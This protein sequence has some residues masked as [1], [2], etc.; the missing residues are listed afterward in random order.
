[1]FR[2]WGANPETAAF[3]SGSLSCLILAEKGE[4]TKHAPK[5]VGT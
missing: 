5:V 1:M 2:S 4:Q 3:F